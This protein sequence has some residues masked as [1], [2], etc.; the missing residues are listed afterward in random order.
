MLRFRLH[1]KDTSNLRTLHEIF[2]QTKH[3]WWWKINRVFNGLKITKDFFGSVLFI[4]VRKLAAN[5]WQ[6]P[7]HLMILLYRLFCLGG[8]L[9]CYW[10]SSCAWPYEKRKGPAKAKGK[11][12][13]FFGSD[14]AK[15]IFDG[16]CKTDNF[17][18][19]HFSEGG[20]NIPGYISQEVQFQ[21]AF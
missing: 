6:S 14:A 8:S 13:N 3:H 7:F 15:R 16:W 19:T 20:H 5:Y 1:N 12:P 10:F 18:S 9:R 11:S 2:L 17:F 21:D 4:E